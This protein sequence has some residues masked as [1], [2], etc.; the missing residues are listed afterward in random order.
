MESDQKNLQLYIR[1][2]NNDIDT[3]RKGKILI[4]WL[5]FQKVLI[6]FD[7]S[8]KHL[9]EDN[10]L[11]AVQ[12]DTLLAPPLDGSGKNL[13][14]DVAALVDELL[15]AHGV[16]GPGDAL[17]DNGALVKV[18]G[19]EVGGG[20]D[21][22]NAALE[23]LVVGLGA[24]EGGQEGVVDVDDLAGHD[25]AELGGED[26]HVAG[27]DD[28]LDVVL[29]DE[30][31][32]LGL[33]LLL[34]V[35]GDGQVVEFDAVALGEGLEFR[36]VGDD[37]RDLNAELLGLVA[38]EKVV[39]AVTDLGDHDQDARLLGHGVDF[40]VHLQVLCQ[41][42]EGLLEGF[43]VLCMAEVHSH[44]EALRDGVGELLQVEDVEVLLGQ[45]SGDIVHNARLVR[46][47]QGED[48]VVDHLL[49][50]RGGDLFCCKCGALSGR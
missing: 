2:F 17:L 12:E 35:L 48:V 15:G 19:D 21:D 37:D 16:V 45:E 1:R 7:I 41:F 31:E 22:L 29:G 26:L 5:N 42:G 9:V 43:C 32:D 33:L 39:Q 28:E 4:T 8:Y 27:E 6:S 14:L 13:A 50:N 38:E 25:L 18:S 20:A 23:S 40:V 47:G 24:L 11:G 10:S 46:A 44:E 30:L 3:R 36:V 49:F 34:G